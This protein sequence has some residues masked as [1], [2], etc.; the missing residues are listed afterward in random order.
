MSS[1]SNGPYSRLVSAAGGAPVAGVIVKGSQQGLGSLPGG[2]IRRVVWSNK[3]SAGHY[4]QIFADP[5]NC[6]TASAPTNVPQNGN[7]PPNFAL[8]PTSTTT[9]PSY[10][11]WCPNAGSV[12]LDFGVDAVEAPGG[13][14][15]A[16]S[17]T[18][19]VFTVVAAKDAAW[20]I[21]YR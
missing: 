17:S 2:R 5:T 1:V 7:Q 16:A 9:V 20:T 14:V 6:G 19:D 12:V 13:I 10:S 21:D 4:L 11:F 15:L 18:P 8:L 3:G